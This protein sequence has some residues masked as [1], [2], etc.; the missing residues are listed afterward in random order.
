MDYLVIDSPIGK[1]TLGAT[2]KGL[3]TIDFG[4]THETTAETPILKQAKEQLALWFE[5][6]SDCKDLPLD[7]RGTPFQLEVWHLMMGIGRGETKTYGE[8]AGELGR[9]GGARAVGGACGA[10]PLPLIVPCHR[11]LAEGN[12]LNGFAGGLEIKRQLLNLEGA[13]WRE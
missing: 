1:L 5:G 8:I 12:R 9:S 7:L 13:Q 3:A 4:I 10:N 11:V 2:E 6:K